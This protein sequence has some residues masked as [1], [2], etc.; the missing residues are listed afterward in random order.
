MLFLAVV[1]NFVQFDWIKFSLPWKLSIDKDLSFQNL[2]RKMIPSKLQI[3]DLNV[4]IN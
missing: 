1:K 4:L 2:D 3:I